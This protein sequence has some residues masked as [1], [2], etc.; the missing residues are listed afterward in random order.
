MNV[1]V[2]FFVLLEV[3]IGIRIFICLVNIVL[4]FYLCDL[5]II[6]LV[7]IIVSGL[8][9]VIFFVNVIVVLRVVFGLVKM[10]MSFSLCVC[11]VGRLLLVS[12]NFM[13]IVYGMCFGNCSNFLLL[14][15]RF[16]LILGIL[17]VEFLVVMIRLVVSVSLVLF[18][19]V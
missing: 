14:V 16:C 5:V 8:L 6:C 12:V 7:V 18:V 3:N 15:I 9:V 13:V 19:N 11:L 1:I 17:N 4:G 2:F 10:L